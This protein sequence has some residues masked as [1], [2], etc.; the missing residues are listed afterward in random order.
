MRASFDRLQVN[1]ADTHGEA[2]DYLVMNSDGTVAQTI[3]IPDAS[4]T[5]LRRSEY[6]SRDGIA[7]TEGYVVT[8]GRSYLPTVKITDRIRIGGADYVVDDRQTTNAKHE[9]IV[10]QTIRREVTGGEHSHDRRAPD[11]AGGGTT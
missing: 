8:F 10:V 7:Q 11:R 6:V 5:Q 2:V 9:C 1:V 3:A 4:V